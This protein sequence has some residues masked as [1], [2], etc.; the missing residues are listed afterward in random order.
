LRKVC[1]RLGDLPFHGKLILVK[2]DQFDII[3]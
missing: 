1:D 2:T 3:C